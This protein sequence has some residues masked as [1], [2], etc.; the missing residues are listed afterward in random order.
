MIRVDSGNLPIKKK[1]QELEY[2]VGVSLWPFAE[3]I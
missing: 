3:H 1:A 2:S